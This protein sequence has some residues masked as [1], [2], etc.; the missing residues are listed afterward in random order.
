MP[1]RKLPD[2]ARQEDILRAAYDVAARRG[3]SALSLRAVAERAK[4]S[5]GTVLF[6]FKRRDVLVAELLDRVL[7]ATVILRIPDDVARRTRPAD[8]LLDL[9]RVEMERL[10]NESRHFRLLLEYWTLGVRSAPIRLKLTNALDE[11]RTAWKDL[12][13]PV[14]DA[15]RGPYAVAGED[16]QGLRY[17]LADSDGLAAV[18]VS[19]VHG[20]ALQAV[21]DSARFDVQEH[22]AAAA[23]MLDAAVSPVTT[24]ATSGTSV[25]KRDR[26]RVA[27][28]RSRA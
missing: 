22:F 27:L 21:I 12:C 6:H 26:N 7:Y 14:V 4:V 28:R 5:H 25:R 13:A 18:A 9:L 24:R 11:Y 20:C 15:A 8:K 23:R 17:R 16:V 19:L 10:S 3:L 1:G 2:E